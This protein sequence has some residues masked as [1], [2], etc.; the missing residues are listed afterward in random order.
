M[1]GPW[2]AFAGGVGGGILGYATGGNVPGANLGGR[3]GRGSVMVA[4]KHGR[5][6]EIATPRGANVIGTQQ[7]SQILAASQI[8]RE[9][10][11]NLV[12]AI[13]RLI[14]KLDTIDPGGRRQVA[15]A[16][17]PAASTVVLEIDGAR[18][19]EVTLNAMRDRHEIAVV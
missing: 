12:G 4:D 6:T 15:A 17:S 19:G 10:M 8:N 13:G 1:A 16:P 11:A 3:F 18:L 14:V 2:G 9:A 7:T 5:G